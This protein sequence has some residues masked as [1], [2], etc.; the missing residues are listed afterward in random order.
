MG[1]FGS[2]SLKR[3]LKSN[4]PKE[5]LRAGALHCRY[6]CRW[7]DSNRR[8]K[9]HEALVPRNDSLTALDEQVDNFHKC[10]VCSTVLFSIGCHKKLNYINSTA[11]C[12]Y[13]RNISARNISARNISLR[14]YKKRTNS[15]RNIPLRKYSSRNISFPT[16]SL[17]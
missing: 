10:K 1:V 5:P 11:I 16:Y 9:T 3:Q 4:F 17:L 13:M 15:V 2:Q 14:T 8:L 7:W 12:V 6:K